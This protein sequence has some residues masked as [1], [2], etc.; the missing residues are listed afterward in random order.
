MDG[1]N[2]I[3]GLY[4]LCILLGL[5]YVNYFVSPFINAD[6]IWLPVLASCVF[7]FFNFRQRAKC[8]LGDVGSITVALWIIF[9]MLEL[10]LKTKEYKYILFLVV[11]GVDT[12]L[13]IIHRLIRGENIFEAHRLHFYQVLSNEYKIQHRLVALYYSIAQIV[14][15]AI[16]VFLYNRVAD[17]LLF[18]IIVFPLILLYTLKFYLLK[19]SN[20]KLNS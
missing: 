4:T 7:L 9:V 19:K 2:G 13:T 16:V 17:L 1:V 15:S 3:T 11:Y 10:I 8:F 6:L 20:L 14:V 18:V 5:Q 12:I